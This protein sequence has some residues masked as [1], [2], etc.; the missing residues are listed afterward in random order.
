MS[1]QNH[2]VGILSLTSPLHVASMDNPEKT[3]GQYII[4][5]GARVEIP[6]FPANNLRGRLRRKAAALV[7][8]ALTMRQQKVSVELYSGLTT[9][10]CDNRPES[11]QTIEEISRA[12]RNLYMGLMGG[13]VRTLRTGF[14]TQDMYPIVSSTVAAGL[15]PAN[16][17]SR[18]EEKM[19]TITGAAG[20]VRNIENHWDLTDARHCLHVDDV[21]RVMRPDEMMA[22][23]TNP[24]ESVSEYQVKMLG[25]RQERKVEGSETKK[26]DVGNI[27]NIRAIVP[28]TNLFCRIDM[29]DTLTDA[30]VGLLITSLRDLLNEN[31]LGG[32]GRI[33][34]G[35]FRASDF[36]LVR[37]GNRFPL[38]REDEN[39]VLMFTEAAA[40]SVQAMQDELATVTSE[41]L[42]A[43][44]THLEEAKP[45]APKDKAAKKAK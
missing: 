2:I 27:F 23:I 38:F 25:N 43:F 42:A 14:S 10:A 20:A 4:S 28:G 16:F 5:N 21:S 13:G 3:M 35:K 8:S 12:K 32:Y 30:Q 24:L 39:G 17:G 45:V 29:K 37:N 11:N 15:V 9:G 19:P 1:H 36:E 33:G 18:G 34:F 26:A 7:L 22:H 44:W 6:Y 40:D 31:S 41:E